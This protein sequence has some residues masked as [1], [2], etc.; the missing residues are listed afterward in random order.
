MAETQCVFFEASKYAKCTN[1][2]MDS[3]RSRISRSHQQGKRCDSLHNK[4]R[5]KDLARE[6]RETQLVEPQVR[7]QKQASGSRR[8]GGR[9]NI[10][11]ND[12]TVAK[13]RAGAMIRLHV[14]YK[15]YYESTSPVQI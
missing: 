11:G 12:A 15:R 2:S 13:V 7:K 14:M 3:P 6:E 8:F 4:M 9:N 5:E 10:H 1:L